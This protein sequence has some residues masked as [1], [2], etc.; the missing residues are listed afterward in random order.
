[1]VA[2]S[3]ICL[4]GYKRP[5]EIACNTRK[6]PRWLGPIAKTLPSPRPAF[7]YAPTHHCLSEGNTFN[8]SW[9]DRLL[10]YAGETMCSFGAA[11]NL[12]DRAEDVR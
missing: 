10:M 3:R 5:W 8:L 4:R 1:M 12:R 9:Y 11:R 2:A 7:F 6:R